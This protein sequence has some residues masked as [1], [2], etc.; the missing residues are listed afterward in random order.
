M[1]EWFARNP[2]AAN[3][4]MVTI[5]IVGVLSAWRAIPLEVFPSF[6][7]DQVHVTTAF[8]GATPKSVE[9]GITNRIEEAIYTVEGVGK[10][11]SASSEGLS[12]IL[13]EI[14]EGYDKRVILNNIKLKVD[15]LNT[16]PSNAENSI[17]SL[18]AR[19]QGVIQV[20]VAGDV[21]QKTLRLTADKVRT[22]LL[23]KA[24]ITLV[25]LLGVSDYE[26][27]V[28][29]SPTTLESYGLTLSEVAAAIND[30][31]ADISAG[32]L[33]TLSGDILVRTNGQAFNQNEFSTI[34]IITSSGADPILLGDIATIVDGFE[35][36]PLESIF[37]GKPAVMMNVTRTGQQS[38]IQI[39]KVVRDYI[40]DYNNNNSA[41]E[42]KLDYWDDDSK[43][44]KARLSTLIKSGIYGS[45]LVL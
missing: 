42:I 12:S 9:D 13:A 17:V 6:E 11:T 1:I 21:D 19:N 36:Q 43:V 8:R 39:A 45:I 27:S 16:L 31:S 28:E 44:V 20:V 10:L 18:V 2:V 26:I 5:I 7:L 38:S 3:L 23:A 29:I 40:S 24:E 15:S 32:N 30:G 35:D 4:L 41:S 33:R 14:D 22:E 37:N 34:P 25:E